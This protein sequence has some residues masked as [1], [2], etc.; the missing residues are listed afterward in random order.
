MSLWLPPLVTAAAWRSLTRHRLQ[1]MLV[2]GGLVL[3]VAVVVAMD[4]A[5]DSADQAYRTATGQL[6]GGRTHVIS[7]PGLTL[8]EDILSRLRRELGLYRS[9]P[10]VSGRLRLRLD[11]AAEDFEV[12]GVDAFSESSLGR[13]LHLTQPLRA[14][15]AGDR[16]AIA[17]YANA[18]DAKS[19]GWQPGV[20][21]G[22]QVGNRTYV[23]RLVATMEQ[24]AGRGLLIMDIADAQDVLQMPGQLSRIDLAMADDAQALAAVRALLP[25]DAMITGQQQQLDG[26]QRLTRAFRINL[27]AMSLLA[28]LIGGFLIY[29]AMLVAVLQRYFLFGRLRALGVSRGQLLALV[30]REA[31]SIGLVAV[32]LGLLLGTLLGQGLLQL[33]VRTVNDL[34]LP[35]HSAQL[36]LAPAVVYKA[37]AFGLGMTLLAAMPPALEAM[38]VPPGALL[39]GYGWEARLRRRLPWLAAVGG[40]LILAGA[41]G[42]LRAD[43]GLL[44]D[45]ASLFVCVAG[46]ALLLPPL[47]SLLLH[48]LSAF[49]RRFGR[50]PQLAV[51]NNQRN[52]RRTAVATLTLSIAVA[53]V[54]GVALMVA[55][56]RHSL[57]DW[58]AYRL[59]ADIYVRDD[60]GNGIDEQLLE[61]LRTLPEVRQVAPGLQTQ[62]ATTWGTVQAT[63]VDVDIATLRAYKLLAGDTAAA[64]DALRAGAAVLVSE[65]LA[66]HHRLR[67]DD[68]LNL[69]TPAGEQGF[70]VAGVFR[71]Y[72]S[73]Q[74]RLLLDRQ[75]YGRRWGDWRVSNV[76]I[77]V[78]ETA[79]LGPL[80]AQLQPRLQSRGLQARASGEIRRI[81]LAIFDRT[82]TVTDVVRQLAVL[83]SA[84]GILAAFI[85]LQLE[86]RR[87]LAILRALGLTPGQLWR[88]LVLESTMLGALGGAL[89]LPLGVGLAYALVHIINI[90]SFGWSM[91][92]LVS[93]GLLMQSWLLATGAA[94]LA[95]LYPAAR[96][97][98]APP[99]AQLQGE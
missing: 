66:R 38:A 62:V 65:P 25:V 4:I 81:S 22:T 20:S 59:Q 54:T 55:S 23:L 24:D 48:L 26:L 77:S 2:L 14:P 97:A 3:G 79:P 45:F 17:V 42:L 56:F 31:F 39:A 27:V 71:D 41:T 75:V 83:V 51:R 88:L 72:G 84:L 61:E 35:L 29:N 9:A 15:A 74:G 91:D 90:K 53:T 52:L 63:A 99:A 1:G 57:E 13:D 30:L 11:G 76:A 33:V 93:P 70:L 78:S 16:A 87:E 7:R 89:A 5:I 21:R 68:R 69:I 98:L 28:L 92:L 19:L 64:V 37:L 40:L 73:E 86:R 49:F 36:R 67:P 12:L 94:M 32:V 50:L 43:S 47:L 82:F 8:S 58:L 46:F 80:L 18:G 44:E 10:V 96:G 95:A 34:Y 6:S 85:T 60:S